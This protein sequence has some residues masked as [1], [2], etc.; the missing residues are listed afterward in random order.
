LDALLTTTSNANSPTGY[1]LWDFVVQGGVVPIIS[2][3]RQDEQQAAV[4][5]FTVLNGIPQLTGIGVD[6]LGALTGNT[7]FGTVDSQIT[8]GILACGVNYGPSYSLVNGNLKTTI[9]RAQVA[10]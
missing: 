2:G 3:V 1:P 8:Q 6:W 7:S 5:A 4:A 10:T 9:Q